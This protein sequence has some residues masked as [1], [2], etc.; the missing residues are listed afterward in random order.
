MDCSH[1]PDPQ[2]PKRSDIRLVFPARILPICLSVAAIVMGMAWSWWWLIAI[3]FI[4]LGSIGAQPNLNVADGCL[5]L[6]A[7]VAGFCI[8]RLHELL[9]LA[10]VM[11]IV[12]GY[13]AGFIEKILTMKPLP[14]KAPPP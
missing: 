9:G 11:G 2:I 1:H 10:I 4:W 8:L 6:V 12:T 5:S 7:A 14:E 13:I 3:P